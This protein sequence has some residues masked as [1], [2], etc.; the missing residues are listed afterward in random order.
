MKYTYKVVSLEGFLS[1]QKE[2]RTSVASFD[3]AANGVANALEILINFYAEDGWEYVM[4]EQF[5][6]NFFKTTGAAVFEALFPNAATNG[7][8][9][10]FIFRKMLSIEELEEKKK[11]DE[12]RVKKIRDDSKN[13]GL[14]NT[15][16]V[17]T[18]DAKCPSCE[19]LLNA[20]D[21]AC[22]KCQ[23]DFGPFSSW[24]PVKI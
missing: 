2:L 24:R 18:A 9:P 23:A 5:D 21:A 1:Q 20:K 15:E 14:T 22:W 8:R 6:V 11:Q 16:M 17:E 4:S 13:K 19:A 7:P 10:V 3:E 12:E